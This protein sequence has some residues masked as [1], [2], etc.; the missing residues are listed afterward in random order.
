MFENGRYVGPL[1][2]L[3]GVWPRWVLRFVKEQARYETLSSD[4]APD[5]E[6]D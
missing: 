5:H 3:S 4:Q 6:V 1:E 2:T